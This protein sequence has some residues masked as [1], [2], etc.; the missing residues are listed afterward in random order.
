MRSH[1]LDRQAPPGG[2]T[3]QRT[4][5]KSVRHSDQALRAALTISQSDLFGLTLSQGGLMNL[6]R[7]AQERFHPGREVAVSA[8]RRAAVV[9]SD[10]TGV[11]IEGS[12][13]YQ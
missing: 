3:D 9:A 6:L 8:L 11:R 4:D 12:N 5:T 7:R 1:L 2:P 13:A 10:E